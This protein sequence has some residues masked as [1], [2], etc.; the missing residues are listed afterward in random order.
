MR[1]GPRLQQNSAITAATNAIISVLSAV[2]CCAKSS[3]DTTGLWKLLS[4]R[5][6]I[7]LTLRTG[8]VCYFCPP[9]HIN[10]LVIVKCEN[11]G[12]RYRRKIKTWKKPSKAPLPVGSS[13]VKE[14]R[15]KVSVMPLFVT[16]KLWINA[17]YCLALCC[18]SE[19]WELNPQGSQLL[20]KTHSNTQVIR[21]ELNPLLPK[22]ST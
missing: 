20:H 14:C 6:T 1:N 21:K 15:K 10:I 18:A 12:G 19:A 9:S 17:L 7:P 13:C 4:L 3:T 22:A 2:N 16:C 11:R 8:L 5:M